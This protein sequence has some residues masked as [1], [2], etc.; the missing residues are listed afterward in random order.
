[1]KKDL[2]LSEIKTIELEILKHFKSFCNENNISFY[3]SNGTL[4]GAVKYGG[5]IPWD[6]DIDVFVPREDY[7]RLIETYKNSEKFKLFSSQRD[8]KFRFTFAK[9][10]DATTIKA[11]N[12]IDNGVEL[13][14]DMDIFPL[15]TCSQQI[16]KKSILLKIKVLQNCC[17][18][19]KFISSKG[20]PVHKRMVID[21]CRLFGY[22]FFAERLVKLIKRETSSGSA[23]AGCLMWPIYGKAEIIPADVFKD[24]VDVTFEGETFP[25]PAGYDLYLRSLYGNYHL[26]PPKEA[27]KTHHSFKAFQI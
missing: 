7:D 14:V 22:S 25:A 8:D 5:F 3:L 10:C 20:K 15:D 27:Q 11:E 1:M 12:N 17:I 9:L 24:T 2:S 18:L 4:L 23:Y 16:F 26:D 21:I 19:A 6:D 13:G